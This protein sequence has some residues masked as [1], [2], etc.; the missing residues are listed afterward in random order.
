MLNNLI[1]VFHCAECGDP[2]YM[3]DASKS[4]KPN[5]RTSIFSPPM[6]EHFSNISRLFIRPCDN[7]KEKYAKPA[8]LLSEALECMN[9]S[10]GGEVYD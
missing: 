6:P 4:A 9:V 1:T 8:R 10:K 3:C 5:I 7:C 2:L